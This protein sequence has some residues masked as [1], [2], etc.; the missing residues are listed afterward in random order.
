MSE[1]I[2][3]IG[4]ATAESRKAQ[5]MEKGRQY[6]DAGNL[7]KARVE[8]RNALQIAPKELHAE[9]RQLRDLVGHLERGRVELVVGHHTRHDAVGQCLAGLHDSAGE[10][11]VGREA[12][13]GDLEETGDAARVGY[14]T[15]VQLG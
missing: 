1:K 12:V 6:L 4:Q 13:P 9:R 10:R 3:P 15:V 5:H 8:F 11:H 14:D 7:E 2:T